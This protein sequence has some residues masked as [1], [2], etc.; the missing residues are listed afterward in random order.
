MGGVEKADPRNI[1]NSGGNLQ[2]REAEKNSRGWKE[3][4]AQGLDLSHSLSLFSVFI[5]F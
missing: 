5:S 2:G 1:G 3:L 4:W